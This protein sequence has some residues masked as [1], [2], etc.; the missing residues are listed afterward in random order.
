[1]YCAVNNPYTYIFLR[2]ASPF[3]LLCVATSPMEICAGEEAAYCYSECR[4]GAQEYRK[5]VSPNLHLEQ[6]WG[7]P[8]KPH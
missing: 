4:I 7:K 3:D 8:R 2:G 6:E 1:M 5:L